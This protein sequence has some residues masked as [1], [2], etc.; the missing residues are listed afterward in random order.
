MGIGSLRDLYLDELF[1]V[2]DAE[3]QASR[4]CARLTDSARAPALRG[5]LARLA[6]ESRLH[7]E[8]LQLILTHWGEPVRICRCR[9]VEAIVQQADDRVHAA[10]TPAICDASI[11]AAIRRI[12]YYEM[13][14]YN[15]AQTSARQLN[16]M[17]DARL[18]Q[19]SLDDEERALERFTDI[20]EA[21]AKDEG[22]STESPLESREDAGQWG[23]SGAAAST[24]GRPR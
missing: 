8:R 5:A 18:L 6:Q 7:L 15:C 1:D 14:V 2:Y 10:K 4:A 17:D 23:A 9:A 11:L 16:R 3:A 12:E 20:A 13:A 21:P 24:I 22:R 19:E